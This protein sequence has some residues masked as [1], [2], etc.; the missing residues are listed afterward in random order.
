MQLSIMI[1]F[2]QQF[3]ILLALLVSDRA[4]TAYLVFNIFYCDDNRQSWNN[5]VRSAI[6]NINVILLDSLAWL[7][8][9]NF[10]KKDSNYLCSWRMDQRDF[11]GCCNL[12]RDSSLGNLGGIIETCGKAKSGLNN[13]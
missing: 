12:S 3:E 4:G 11:L 6:N 1:F 8:L 7:V 5:T 2:Y 10:I 13:V 9:V